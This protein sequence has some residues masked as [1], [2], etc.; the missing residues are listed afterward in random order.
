MANTKHDKLS[1]KYRRHLLSG[2]RF[3]S[4]LLLY[5]PNDRIPANRLCKTRFTEDKGGSS[6]FS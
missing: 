2:A 4:V 5:L 6:L 1:S 3:L